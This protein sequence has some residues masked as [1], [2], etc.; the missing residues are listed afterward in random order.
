MTAGFST[1]D[2]IVFILYALVILSIGLWVSRTKKGVQ[3]TAQEYF[4]ADKSL[5]WWAVGASLIAA[6]ISAEHFI[7]TSGSGFAIGLAISAYEW[8]AAIALIVVAKYFLPVFIDNGIYTMPQFLQQRFNRGVSTAFA[9]FWLLVYVFVNLTSVSYLGALAME[10]IMGVPLVYGIIGLLIFS[11]IY[12]IYGGLEAVAWT[13]VVQ[14][15]VLVGGGLVTTYLAL[16]AVGEG[17][18]IVS[19][20]ANLYEKG[21]NHF[22]MI[23]PEG[24]ISV[25]DGEGGTRDAF[26]DLPGVAVIVG[27]MWITNLGYWG[28]N[29][30]II[31]KGLAA[32]N[33]NEAKRGLLFAGY[34]KILM[35]VIV[36]IPGIAAYVLINDY[37]G[38]EL[39]AILGKPI[40]EI[41]LIDKS[42]AAYPWLL[43]NFVPAGIRGL[44]FAA[45]TAAIVSS[46]ASMVNSTS[47][48]FT[49]D[50]YRSYFKPSASNRELVL[51]GRVV[52]AI[53][54]GIAMVVAPELSSLDQVFQYIQ[55]YTGYIYPGAVVV[56]AM[57]LFW[58]QMT[59]NAALWTAIATIPAGILFKFFYPE[60]PFIIRMGY[61]FIILCVIASVISF[62]EKG[63]KVK[64]PLPEGSRQ[65][66]L[67]N[68]SYLFFALGLI[69]LVLTI[70]LTPEYNYLGIE[71]A[72]MLA[73]LFL[74]L[75]IILYTNAK[76]EMADKK[77]IVTDPVIFNTGTP[78]NIGAAGIIL[79]IGLLYYFFWM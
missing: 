69:T 15:I 76:M 65:R 10:T 42:D 23:I 13:D 41:G 49:M 67:V 18:G 55:E 48:I 56:F 78:F 5:T 38:A 52:A 6:N 37:T 17:D 79:I 20:F 32:K 2:Y 45:L 34:L 46:L 62:T 44:A 59:P 33:I 58:K 74:M 28:F 24:T 47:T 26:Q 54:L 4:L 61:V 25:P 51:V 63:T 68:V 7:G 1:L 31:Q 16:D 35:P 39:S 29:Q 12:S 71:S 53:A 11:G 19:G 30:Y 64:T 21:R 9:V 50:I 40:E 22:M 14:V 27:A 77:A 43:K 70:V 66:Y 36:V 57:G 3:K 73:V 75:G 60:M 72:Y 8:I